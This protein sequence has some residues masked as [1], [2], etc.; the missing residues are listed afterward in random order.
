MP[1]LALYL[2]LAVAVTLLLMDATGQ[3]RFSA[4]AARRLRAVG[5]VAAAGP[6]LAPMA[7]LLAGRLDVGWPFPLIAMAYLGLF[8]AWTAAVAG[9]L[10]GPRGG[11]GL[12]RTIYAALIFLAALPSTVLLVLTPFVAIAGL[13]LARP[14]VED[15]GVDSPRD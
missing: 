15:D 13:G 5:I 8:L 1:V 11:G 12:R 10:G 7:A 6:G 4:G 9:W 2:C 14:L 3:M